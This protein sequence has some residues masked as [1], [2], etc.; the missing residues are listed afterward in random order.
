MKFGVVQCS[1]CKRALGVRGDSKT[2][3]CPQCGKKMV[4]KKVNILVE[5]YTEKELAKAVMELN[6]R[7]KEGEE[8]VEQDI[9]LIEDY[10]G[11]RDGSTGKTPQDVYEEVVG[12]VSGL[13]GEGRIVEAVKELCR[14]LEEFTEKDFK[15][16]LKRTG[17]GD[18]KICEDHINNLIN[19]GIIY[20]PRRGVY[21]CLENQLI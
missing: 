17:I 14:L 11:L 7:F 4:L 5:L 13:K 6:T 3:T 21:R 9:R 12:R 18:D 2:A 1:H 16:V 19:S 10:R 20:E 8:I 15:E